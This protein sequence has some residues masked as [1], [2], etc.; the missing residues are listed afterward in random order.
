MMIEGGR[1]TYKAIFKMLSLTGFMHT[2]SCLFSTPHFSLLTF[3]L[4]I[5][6]RYH[7]LSI[8]LH[9]HSERL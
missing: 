9:V 2:L 6:Y 7:G 1:V 4:F 5:W 3:I 8:Y